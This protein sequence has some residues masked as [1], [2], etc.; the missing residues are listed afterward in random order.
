M[1]A[2]TLVLGNAGPESFNLKALQD[3]KIQALAGII[4]VVEDPEF[5]KVTPAQRPARVTI[6]FEDGSKVDNTVLGSKGDPDQPMSEG[7]LRDKSP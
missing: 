7:E 1:I 4:E 5:T 3:L 2:A 6:N